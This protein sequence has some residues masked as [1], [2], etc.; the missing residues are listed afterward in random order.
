MKVTP[1]FYYN[2]LAVCCFEGETMAQYLAC[3]TPEQ[4]V[5]AQALAE[6]LCY[7]LGQAWLHR[8]DLVDIS[9]EEKMWK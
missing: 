3:W 2:F 7:V 6:S 5:W 9:S 1:L 4:G 8:L